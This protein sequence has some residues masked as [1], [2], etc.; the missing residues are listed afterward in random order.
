MDNVHNCSTTSVPALLSA[1]KMALAQL[2]KQVESSKGRLKPIRV[3]VIDSLG[4]LFHSLDRTTTTTLV[5]RSKILSEIS[6]LIHGVA[7]SK[8]AAVI[9]INQVSDVFHGDSYSSP[10]PPSDPDQAPE[11]NYKDQSIWFSRAPPL[12]G[13]YPPREATMGLAWANQ[14]NT[15]IMVSRTRRRLRPSEGVSINTSN[16]RRKGPGDSSTDNGPIPQESRYE[17]EGDEEA[18]TGTL[19]RNLSIVFSTVCSPSTMDFVILKE[20]IRV[21]EVRAANPN[22]PRPLPQK[23]PELPKPFTAPLVPLTQGFIS[24][25]LTQ[26]AAEGP[27]I[28]HVVPIATEGDAKEDFDTFD[29]EEWANYGIALGD[30]EEQWDAPE[31]EPGNHSTSNAPSPGDFL[32]EDELLESSDVEENFLLDNILEDSTQPNVHL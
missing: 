2:F 1:L 4:S 5:E 21:T 12:A 29:E 24:A 16:K 22:K 19:I 8:Q 9:V 18:V 11:L 3:I 6:Y 32:G 28:A 31:Q 13:V 23:E 7:S 20:G 26:R 14:V 15:R 10:A 30:L 25:R 17:A 27:P